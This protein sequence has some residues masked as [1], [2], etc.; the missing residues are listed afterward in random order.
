MTSD[1]VVS[2]ASELLFIFFKRLIFATA[3]SPVYLLSMTLYSLTLKSTNKLTTMFFTGHTTLSLSL[4]Q[5]Q[6][7][8]T[9]VTV[10]SRSPICWHSIAHCPAPASQTFAPDNKP[11]ENTSTVE[12]DKSRLQFSRSAG[13]ACSS[14]QYKHKTDHRIWAVMGEIIFLEAEKKT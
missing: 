5:Y 3:H 12:K 9:W 8:K 13:K 2:E 6:P 11:R 14:N 1:S 10:P 7:T 4:I